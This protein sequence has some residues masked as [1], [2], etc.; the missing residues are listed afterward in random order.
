MCERLYVLMDTELNREDLVHSN[1][2][3]NSVRVHVS[4]SFSSVV[5]VFA[6]FQL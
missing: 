3:R 4:F 6:S 5:I 1:L 2:Y